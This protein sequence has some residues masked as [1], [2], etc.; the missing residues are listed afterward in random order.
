MARVAAMN[1][2]SFRS[3]APL[4]IVSRAR[5]MPAAIEGTSPAA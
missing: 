3:A 4:A 2:S 1:C 5:S